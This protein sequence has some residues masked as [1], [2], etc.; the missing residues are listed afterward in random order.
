MSGR[1][2]EFTGKGVYAIYSNDEIIYIGSTNNFKKRFAAHYYDFNNS[3]KPL[4]AKM[5]R[6]KA[7]GKIVTIAPLINVESLYTKDE[8]TDRDIQA[9]ELAL[10]NLYRP[11]CNL[12]GISMPYKFIKQRR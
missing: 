10:I 11:I 7:E 2:S 5:R 9:M 4:Y 1:F 6:D 8:I 3:S 12:Q